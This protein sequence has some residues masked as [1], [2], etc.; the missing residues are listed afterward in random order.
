MMTVHLV[1][2]ITEKDVLV[3]LHNSMEDTSLDRTVAPV[4]E[5]MTRK[6]VCFEPEDD[7]RD[8]AE[9]LSTRDF[10]RVPILDEGKL[11]GI[12]SRRDIIRHL[13]DLQQQND[14]MKDNILELLY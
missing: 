3:L 10:R 1:G 7:L 8:I 11:V 9:C 13:Q 2:I 6:V 5:S 4:G 12:I 14:V